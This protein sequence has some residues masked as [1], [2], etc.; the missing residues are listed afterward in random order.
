MKRLKFDELL[1]LQLLW[2]WTRRASREKAKGI[3]YEKVG[4]TTRELI[5][6]R[7][8]FALTKA[9]KRVLRE[10]WTDM[11]QPFPM[12]RLLQGPGECCS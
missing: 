2:A 12:S 9:Q 10:I 1:T 6:K 5:E 7:L 4:E 11:Q 3:A 8:P